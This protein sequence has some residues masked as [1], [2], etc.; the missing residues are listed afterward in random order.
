MHQVVPSGADAYLVK[1]VIMD[2]SDE[3]AI[4]ILTNCREANDG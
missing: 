4:R 3:Q 1:W 2:R